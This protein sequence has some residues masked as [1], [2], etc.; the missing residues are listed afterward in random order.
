MERLLHELTTPEHALVCET[1][2]APP[3]QHLK[4]FPTTRAPAQAPA[5][6]V[7]SASAGYAGSQILSVTAPRDGHPAAEETEDLPGVL[8]ATPDLSHQHAMAAPRKT[9]ESRRRLDEPRA[10]RIQMDVAY[11]LQEVRLLLDEDRF[12]PILEE[13]ACAAVATV[14]RTGISGEEARHHSRQRMRSGSDQQMDV[15]RQEG[16]RQDRQARLR[17]QRGKPVE[18]ILAVCVS[19]EKGTPINPSHDGMMKGAGPVNAWSPRHGS[20]TRR[21]REDCQQYCK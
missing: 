7:G 9:I 14:E 10:E 1:V 15:I 21:S 19:K 17:H 18:K 5:L 20:Q 4:G 2:L 16:P 11:Q 3:P 12:V 8:P 6:Q 13:V